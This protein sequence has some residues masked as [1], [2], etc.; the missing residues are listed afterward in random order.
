[1]N[2]LVQMKF[3]RGNWRAVPRHSH[4]VYRGVQVGVHECM[5]H[6]CSHLRI[7]AIGDHL[8]SVEVGAVR[9]IQVVL[10]VYFGWEVE[11]RVERAGSV[12]GCDGV[13]GAKFPYPGCAGG[14]AVETFL[15]AVAFI[16]CEG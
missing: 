2:V 6:R 7:D 15:D 12:A 5:S 14:R 9:T 10:D 4:F 16:W 13:G 11:L 3:R 1:M 8:G